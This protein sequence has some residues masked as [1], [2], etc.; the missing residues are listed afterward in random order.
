LKNKLGKGEKMVIN[1]A[2][3]GKST[4][5]TNLE[6]ALKKAETR[7]VNNTDGREIKSQ[8]VFNVQNHYSEP[9]LNVADYFCWS[10]QRVFEKGEI[11]YYNYL[12]DRI[13]VI[14]DLYDSEKYNNWK[15]YYNPKN[16]LTSENKISPPL[17]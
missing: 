9:L 13:P 1:I 11:R 7:F 12:S 3:R 6:L 4:R 2:E 14:I 8:I 10:I 5:N 15:N 16:P 17:H